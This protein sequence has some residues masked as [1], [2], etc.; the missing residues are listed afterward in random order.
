MFIDYCRLFLYLR[1]ILSTIPVN[2]NDE[3]MDDFSDDEIDDNYEKDILGD[4][5]Y[6]SIQ[7]LT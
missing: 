4:G 6:M 3:Y 7:F 2:L 1:L 5:K